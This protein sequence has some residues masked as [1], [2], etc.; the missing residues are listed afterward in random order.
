MFC[1]TKHLSTNNTVVGTQFHNFPEV[2]IPIVADMS[3]DFLSKVIDPSPCA[4]IYAHAQKNVG[5][6]GVTAVVIRKSILENSP[7]DLPELLDYRTHIER[8]SNY[9]TPPCFSIYMMWHILRWIEEDIGG[10]EAMEKINRQKSSALYDF[11]DATP[12]FD[13]PVDLGSRSRMN[14]VFTLPT[15]SLEEQ[16]IQKAF[17]SGLVGVA[18]HRTKGG[19]RV[20]LYNAVTLD[21]VKNLIEFMDKFAQKTNYQ[22]SA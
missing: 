12:L 18:G 7:D 17:A 14:V 19:Y 9:H 22:K 2:P 11:I 15:K 1:A 21:A 6:S 8:K 5:L 13:C 20:S 10:V 3:S 16:F 4:C